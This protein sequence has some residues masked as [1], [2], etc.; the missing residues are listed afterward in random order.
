MYSNLVLSGGAVK[1][2]VLLGAVK[3]LEENDLIK[4]FKNYI[5]SSAG[6][7]IIFFIIIGYKSEEIN[8]ILITEIKNIINLNYD[9]IDNFLMDYGIDN[10][11]KNKEILKKYL[12][13][14]TELNDITFIEFTK[15]YG[16]NLI[17]T[18]TNLTTRETDYFNINN[19]PE[20]SIIDALVI[21]SC[22]PLIYKP[23]EYNDNLY[24][25]GGI[26]NNFAYNYFKNKND[27]LGINVT[28]DYSRKND[29]F[30]N[31]FN[32][33]ILSL[34]NKIIDL[35]INN[36]ENVCVINFDESRKDGIN[37]S[38]DELEISIDDDI[39]NE[40]YKYGYDIFK[41]FLDNIINI[42]KSINPS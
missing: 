16:L 9:N 26:Y 30:I 27:T 18:G 6:A 11:N 2:V 41:I 42:K 1:S 17:I 29:T 36:S 25:D 28:Y 23:I 8:K 3:Y 35:N 15:K 39:I 14:K 24:I 5:G 4:D 31:Y 21:T 37:F 40:N 13:K 33:I 20:M 38:I 10:T 32:N 7:I 22:L 19:N 12:Y 34:M